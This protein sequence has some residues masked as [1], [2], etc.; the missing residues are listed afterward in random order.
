TAG[1]RRGGDLSS[2]DGCGRGTGRNRGWRES[3]D[4]GRATAGR[5][6]TGTT[7]PRQSRFG[8]R[9]FRL[10]EQRGFPRVPGRTGGAGLRV[11]TGRGTGRVVALGAHIAVGT[12]FGER[13]EFLLRRADIAHRER[14]PG[15]SGHLRRRTR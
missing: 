3:A 5:A 2:R 9:A 13:T 1:V 7:G 4:P 15:I 14:T 6:T 11:V 12:H 10:I 8:K